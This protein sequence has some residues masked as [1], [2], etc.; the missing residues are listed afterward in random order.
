LGS[1][2]ALSTYDFVTNGFIS[3]FYVTI[4]ALSR[5]IGFEW[6]QPYFDRRIIDF[7]LSL[8]PHIYFS[9]GY[10]RFVLREA[11][12]DILPE[13]VRLRVSKGSLNTLVKRGIQ[14]QEREKIHSFIENSIAVQLGLVNE[15]HLLRAWKSFWEDGQYPIKPLTAYLC[16]EAWLRH[17]E[18][19]RKR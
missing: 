14:G 5:Y 18:K 3:A 1:R 9:G 7:M 10:S 16:A 12:K 6:R 2:C 8:P 13:K 19:I 4:N 17:Q 15:N 11:M